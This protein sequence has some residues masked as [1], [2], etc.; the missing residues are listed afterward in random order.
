MHYPIL[1]F[2]AIQPTSIATSANCSSRPSYR[3]TSDRMFARLFRERVDD[4]R[5]AESRPD[6]SELLH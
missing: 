6:Y 3:P 2:L 1:T 5:P 4:H